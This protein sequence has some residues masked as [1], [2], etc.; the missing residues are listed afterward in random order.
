MRF[1]VAPF[2]LVFGLLCLAPAL[3]QDAPVKEEPKPAEPAN[4]EAAKTDEP[5]PAEEAAPAKDEAKPTEEAKPKEEAKP[6]EEVK[7]AAVP[8][9]AAAPAKAEAPAKEM[10]AC[11]KAF[12][13]LADSYKKAYDD[14]NKWIAQVDAQTSAASEKTKK[15]Q[16]QIQA[17]ETAITSAKLAKDDAKVKSLT[18]ENKQLWTDFNEAKKAQDKSCSGFSK[19]VS[20]RVKQQNDAINKALADVKAQAK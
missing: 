17:N 12:V 11:A 10:S 15:L 7:P 4:P 14:M 18:K 20:D 13:P 1:V 3:A 2:A 8:A 16:D 19:E 9:K 6:T 5:K